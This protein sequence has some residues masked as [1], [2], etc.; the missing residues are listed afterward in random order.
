MA[1]KLT[2]SIQEGFRRAGASPAES[3]VHDKEE[4]HSLQVRGGDSRHEMINSVNLL[5][6]GQKVYDRDTINQKVRI[7][8]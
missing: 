3:D 8:N 4:T 1:R 5:C 7:N 2:Q 6:T